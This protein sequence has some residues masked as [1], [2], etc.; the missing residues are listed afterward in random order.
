MKKQVNELNRN[1]S[2]E[3]VQMT[4]NT[5]R[6]GQHTWFWNVFF[7][8]FSLRLCFFFDSQVYLLEATNG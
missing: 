6:N 5:W 7:H 1:F 2:K 3:D 4:K 8:L